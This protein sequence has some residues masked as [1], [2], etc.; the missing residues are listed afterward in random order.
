MREVAYPETTSMCPPPEKYLEDH[1]R[2]QPP[3]W[4]PAHHAARQVFELIHCHTDVVGHMRSI[5]AP[6]PVLADSVS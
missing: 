1:P 2:N 3:V 4:L 6:R 5:G